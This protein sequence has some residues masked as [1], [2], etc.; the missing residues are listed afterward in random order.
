M[1]STRSSVLILGL[2]LLLAYAAA[3]PVAAQTAPPAQKPP[4]SQATGPVPPTP[5]AQAPSLGGR[6]LDDEARELLKLF[7]FPFPVEEADEKAAA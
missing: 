7:G 5:A 3:L 6:V 1:S 4:A 2:A